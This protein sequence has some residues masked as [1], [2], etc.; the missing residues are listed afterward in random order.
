MVKA[1]ARN[2][3]RKRRQVE[4]AIAFELMKEGT[5]FTSTDLG[6]SLFGKKHHLSPASYNKRMECLDRIHLMCPRLPHAV[7][8][9][10]KRRKMAFCKRCPESWGLST[11]SKF[12]DNINLLVAS[13]GK[14]YAGHARVAAER[15]DQDK[16]FLKLFQKK[17]AHK[18]AFVEFVQDMKKWSQRP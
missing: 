8:N 7:Q 17:H 13:L 16:E 12:K 9:Q 3:L 4:K 10:W 5:T 6:N 11:G 14:H 15:T 1:A 2:R 18:D